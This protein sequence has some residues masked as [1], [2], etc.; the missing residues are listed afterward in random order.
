MSLSSSDWKKII[1]GLGLVT[2]GALTGGAAIPAL[3]AGA[4]AAGAAGAAG[5][6]TAVGAGLGT[7]GAGLGTAASSPL[8][9]AAGKFVAPILAGQGVAL[10]GSGAAPKFNVD[11]PG[12]IP[13]SQ[14]MDLNA[15]IQKPQQE[16]SRLS[17]LQ[18]G[19]SRRF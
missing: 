11:P 14:P 1:A 3:T 8:L 9:A 19:L 16:Q 2:V 17:R 5:A 7:A 12:A 13:D 6:G 10:A 18:L 15:L 4:S